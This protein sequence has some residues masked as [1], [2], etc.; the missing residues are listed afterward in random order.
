L[1]R[2]FLEIHDRELHQTCPETIAE[3]RFAWQVEF[4]IKPSP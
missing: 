2:T 3:L 1:S 4:C